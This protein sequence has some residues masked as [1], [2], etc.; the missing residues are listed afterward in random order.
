MWIERDDTDRK[1]RQE[2]EKKDQDWETEGERQRQRNRE[3]E[4]MREGWER[5]YR[6]K[7]KE[8]KKDADIMIRKKRQYR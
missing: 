8:R 2:N 4:R 7:A 5:H 6:L 3:R 1:N